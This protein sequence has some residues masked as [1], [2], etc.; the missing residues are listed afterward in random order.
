MHKRRRQ[1]WRISRLFLALH[2]LL[3]LLLWM[4]AIYQG[5]HLAYMVD[6]TEYSRVRDFQIPILA[7][8]IWIPILLIHACAHFYFAGQSE[9]DMVEREAYREGLRDRSRPTAEDAYA[10]DDLT[11][12]DDGE[13]VDWMPESKRK[14]GEE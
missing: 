6:W 1:R 9:M 12:D 14:R 2:I 11:V 5:T 8:L 7:A 4:Y 3:F 13:L 10:A